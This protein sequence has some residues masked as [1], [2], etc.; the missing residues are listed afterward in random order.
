MQR[1]MLNAQHRIFL[2][3]WDFDT[4][5][6]LAMGRRWFQRL[7]RREYP[8]RLGSFLIWL[9][10]HRKGLEI[11]VLKW[12]FGL[13]QFMLRG[14]MLVDLARMVARRDITFKFDTHH[15]VGCSHHQK[16]AV[17]DDKLAVCG[18]IDMTQDRWDTREHL[19]RDRRR[20]RPHGRRYGPWHDATMMFEGEAARVLGVL[21]RERW[22]RAGGEDLH[23]VPIPE[24]SLWPEDLPVQFENVEI[25]IA[26]TRAKHDGSPQVS[27]I[28]QLLLDQIARAKHFIYSENQYFT[29]RKIAEAIRQR[30][31]EDDPPEIVMV[32]PLT[33]E[34]WL[35]QQAMDHARACVIRSLAELDHKR[36]FQVY[37]PYTGKTPI[38]VHA[39][40]MIVD[41]R[42]LR[43]G[44]ANFNNRSMGLDSEC[45][46]FIDCDRPDND[47]AC[48]GIAALRRSLL[49]EH[50]GIEEETVA[51]LL[52]ADPS[53]HK[54]IAEHGRGGDRSL[55]P[56]E[57]PDL[58]GVEETLADS[59]LLDPERPDE[60]FEPFAKGGLFRKGSLLGRA[61]RGARKRIGT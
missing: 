14:Y 25:G 13:L 46:V 48:H 37:V 20:R 16:I 29:S 59:G 39:K 47:H 12:S 24:Q 23:Q 54:L 38:Y 1:A 51:R 49:A 58:N 19:E 52:D 50:C 43:I 28:E 57:V 4:R 55:Q 61:Y 27:E 36:R 3:G 40:L 7:L 35:E 10:R 22:E 32:Q 26:R 41:D 53:M 17:L 6:H 31:K 11:R 9:A 60:M 2:V 18:G 15:P 44:S 33:A 34:G 45:D 8:R 21:S 5:I 42:I 30:L 56:Y